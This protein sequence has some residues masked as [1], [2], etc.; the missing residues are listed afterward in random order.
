LQRRRRGASS[1]S[2][3]GSKSRTEGRQIQCRATSITSKVP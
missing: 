1:E 3:A 2:L